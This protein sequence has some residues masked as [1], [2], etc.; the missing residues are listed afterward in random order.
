MRENLLLRSSREGVHD[1]VPQRDVHLSVFEIVPV[2]DAREIRLGRRRLDDALLHGAK[3]AIPENLPH[4]SYRLL[5][6]FAHLVRLLRCH[7]LVLADLLVEPGFDR[8]RHPRGVCA[9]HGEKSEDEL[10]IFHAEV[11]LLGS[12]HAEQV[13]VPGEVAQQVRVHA[14]IDAVSEFLLVELRGAHV[15]SLEHLEHKVGLRLTRDG[16]HVERMVEDALLQL[17]RKLVERLAVVLRE[18]VQAF[19]RELRAVGKLTLDET[20]DGRQSLFP[21]HDFQPAGANLVEEHRRDGNAQHQRLHQLRR[22]AH[23]PHVLALVR[24]TQVHLIPVDL[25]DHGRHGEIR[26]LDLKRRAIVRLAEE[27]VGQR[28]R[29]VPLVAGGDAGDALDLLPQRRLR[30]GREGV[31]LSLE[32]VPEVLILRARGG[33]GEEGTRRVRGATRKNRD[34][35]RR[36]SARRVASASGRAVALSGEFRRGSG[37]GGRGVE[38]RVDDRGGFRGSQG[39][40][41]VARRDLRVRSRARV[42]AERR[43][44]AARISRGKPRDPPEGASGLRDMMMIS[45]G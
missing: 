5:K 30:V 10:A 4:Q 25:I 14:L 9:L 17:R 28:I 8:R 36:E 1:R 18:H 44:G 20:P 29:R 24:R 42:G 23:G 38:R 43:V 7:V 27:L 13:F 37:G 32:L 39:G 31:R 3:R 21:I 40:C 2:K 45:R 22:R 26:L 33:W 19:E 11:R 35:Q 6:H 41:D 12:T 15:E 16:V 34:C